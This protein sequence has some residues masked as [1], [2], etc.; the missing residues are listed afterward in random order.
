[1]DVL[2]D[3]LRSARQAGGIDVLVS[4]G[5]IRGVAI[6]ASCLVN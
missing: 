5:E 1:M 6:A 2:R 3:T 4:L